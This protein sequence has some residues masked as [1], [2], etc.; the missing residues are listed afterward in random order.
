MHWLFDLK[1]QLS[2]SGAEQITFGPFGE[3]DPVPSPNGKWLLFEYFHQER[4][5]LPTIWIMPMKGNFS[6]ARALVD[7]DDYNGEPSWSPDS[8]WVC[9]QTL[10]HSGKGNSLFRVN[11]STGEKI[12]LLQLPEGKSIGDST[13]WSVQGT[14]A[15]ELDGD[16]SGLDPATGTLGRLLD[17]RQRFP[18]TPPA[19]LIWS[20]DGTML[21]FATENEETIKSQIWTLNLKTRT[22]RQITGG[23]TDTFPSWLDNHHLLLSRMFSENDSQIGIISLTGGQLKWLT[24]GHDD[25]TPK[26]SPNGEVLFFARATEP[27]PNPNNFNIFAGFH[28]WRMTLAH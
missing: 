20:P 16:I 22:L 17:T 2:P 27:K 8:R 11:A 4:P 10:S 19:H 9:Y 3:T 1:C 26:P 7:D 18:S 25:L 13:A 28:I 15:F 12:R 21:A 24:Q 14:I 6:E 5:N 23:H